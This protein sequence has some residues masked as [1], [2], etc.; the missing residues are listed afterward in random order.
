LFKLDGLIASMMD[1]IFA[2]EL[3]VIAGKTGRAYP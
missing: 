1:R 2:D 3:L